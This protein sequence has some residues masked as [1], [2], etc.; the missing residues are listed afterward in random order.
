VLAA[1][2]TCRPKRAP[3]RMCRVARR[4]L[5]LWLCGRRGTSRCLC[6]CADDSNPGTSRVE[7]LVHDLQPT[8]PP[9]VQVWAALDLAIHGA[10]ST[11]ARSAP[12]IALS[13]QH[14]HV[15][16]NYD[17]VHLSTN[18]GLSVYLMRLLGGY[19]AALFF[20]AGYLQ[21]RAAFICVCVSS[22][23]YD[24]NIPAGNY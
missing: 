14:T 9:N 1:R 19:L 8:V 3:S 7:G 5:P 22:L 21:R 20:M 15:C 24:S 23:L 4:P 10:S 17:M 13:N 2:L 16:M 12:P 11:D 6:V 18:R